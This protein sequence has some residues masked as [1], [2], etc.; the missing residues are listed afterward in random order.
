MRLRAVPPLFVLELVLS[1]AAAIFAAVQ[2]AAYAPYAGVTA[3]LAL[4]ALVY[5]FSACRS[6]RLRR[7]AALVE[8][9]LSPAAMIM[10]LLSA[11]FRWD[12]GYLLS[13]RIG[14]SLYLAVKIAATIAYGVLAGRTGDHVYAAR[15]DLALISAL[16]TLNAVVCAFCYAGATDAVT[17]AF[18]M[19]KLGVNALSTFAVAYLALSYLVTVFSAEKLPLKG[20]IRAVAAFFIKHDLGFIF[21]V[22]FAAI[23]IVVCTVNAHRTAYYSYLAGFYFILFVARVVTHVWNRAI[24]HKH[25]EPAAKSRRKNVLLL[26]NSAW[27]LTFLEAMFM[28][29]ITLSAIRFA[30]TI[31]WWFFV[32]FMFPFSIYNFIHAVIMRHSAAKRD[33]AYIEVMA[34]QSLVASIFSSFA[35]I[36]YFMRYL[37]DSTAV[38]RMWNI[39][40]VAVMATIAAI[41]ISS[42][43]RGIRGAKGRRAVQQAALGAHLPSD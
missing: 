5:F 13:L 17:M 32:A 10:L 34:D 29:L 36:S 16:Y 19:V 37:P 15:R 1:V 40:L 21:G 42:L 26:L 12:A 35:G 20:K 18:L 31:P 25:T 9:F 7:V 33:D 30:S 28:A 38:Q 6:E 11:T 27:F 8:F 41:L 24:E 4:D 2:T 43:V 3:M 14:L 22:V 39:A 23:T